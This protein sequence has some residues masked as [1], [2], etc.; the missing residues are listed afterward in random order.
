MTINT[1]KDL[2]AS[3]PDKQGRFGDYGGKFV[4]E[5]LMAALAELEATFDRGVQKMTWPHLHFPA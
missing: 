2:F 5:T 4:S 1:H 3:V